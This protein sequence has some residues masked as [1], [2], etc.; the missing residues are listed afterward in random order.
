MSIYQAP[1]ADMRFNLF[2]LWKVQQ[3]W[4]QNS[5]LAE[6]IEAD[7]ANA[8]LDEAGKVTAELI[9]PKAQ[10]ADEIGV[11]WQAGSVTTPDH[12]KTNY[13]QLCEGGWTALSGDPEFGGMG[14]PSLWQPCTKK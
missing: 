1:L 14:M 10:L 4:S 13:Q 3:F 11:K 8:I 12:Y 7:T 6:R 2:Q 9:A 5:I